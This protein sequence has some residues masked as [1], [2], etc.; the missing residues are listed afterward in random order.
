MRLIAHRN[1][2]EIASHAVAY[3]EQPRQ[4]ITNGFAKQVDCQAANETI[5]GQMGQV[6]MQS[7]RRGQTPPFTLL[8]NG[9]AVDCANGKPAVAGNPGA[10][11]Y[12]KQGEQRHQRYCGR[13]LRMNRSRLDGRRRPVDVFQII[14]AEM[15]RSI[16]RVMCCNQQFHALFIKLV[17]NANSRQHQR[18]RFQVI[19]RPVGNGSQR[20][21][22]QRVF[23]MKGRGRHHG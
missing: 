7:K 16:G 4:A 2:Q 22:G 19:K 5:S 8:H 6:G 14:L 1:I 10:G 15:K 13:G 18:Q 21:R 9:L 12:E 20:I 3:Q 23:R 11:V 17:G